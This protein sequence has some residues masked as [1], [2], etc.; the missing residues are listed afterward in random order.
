MQSDNA[1]KIN[2]RMSESLTEANIKYNKNIKEIL[3]GGYENNW[4]IF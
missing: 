2:A 3:N 1:P 4:N